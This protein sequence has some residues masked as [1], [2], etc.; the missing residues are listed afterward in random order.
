LRAS[1]RTPLSRCAGCYRFTC[2]TKS[3]PALWRV[4][5]VAS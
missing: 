1:T 4:Q 5:V 2:C 3:P